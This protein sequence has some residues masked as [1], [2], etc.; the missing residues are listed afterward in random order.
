[1]RSDKF[2]FDDIK[3]T[4]QVPPL[5]IQNV[6]PANNQTIDVIFNL[7]VD[8]ASVSA[9]DFSVD[10]GIGSPNSIS[11]QDNV[12][13]LSYDNVLPG[14]HYTLTVSGISDQSGNTI[15]PNATAAFTLFDS[16]TAGDVI[17]N[18]FMYDEPPDQSEYIEIKNSSDKL[19]NLQGWQVGDNSNLKNISASALELEPH[20]LLVLTADSSKLFT[21]YGARA[22]VEI[23]GLPGLN[24]S[25]DA[26]RLL[27]AEGVMADSLTYRSGWGGDEVALERRSE[28]VP[29]TYR[30]NWGHSPH[31]DGGTPGR[32]NQVA[33]D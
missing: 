31:P 32:P 24:N 33:T 26:I 16:F 20:S 23:D 1:S 28:D 11:V 18:E 25:G 4:K 29:G 19:L 13:R 12:V 3:V 8:P 14:S 30:E 2:Y 5:A 9:S 15:A 22:Y 6:N 17:I 7:N 10:N 21:V 27:T